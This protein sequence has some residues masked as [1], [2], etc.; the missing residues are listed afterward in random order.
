M[1]AKCSRP[2][3]R[4]LRRRGSSAGCGK[5]SSTAWVN[6]GLTLLALFALVKFL[7]FALPWLLHGVWVA[8][9]HLQCLEIIKA[10]YGPDATGACWAVIRE[11]WGQYLF[12]FYPVEEWWRPILCFGLMLV[13]LVPPLFADDAKMARRV[14]DADGGADA[15]PPLASGGARAWRSSRRWWSLPEP[16][17][18]RPSPCASWG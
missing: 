16:W 10:N 11:R 7:G 17:R 14:L 6:T 2:C 3:R 15:D 5:I 4:P 18:G 9:S 8:D 1:S 12:G 13:A